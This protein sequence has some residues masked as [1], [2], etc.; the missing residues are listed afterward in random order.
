MKYRHIFSNNIKLLRKHKG[1]TQKEMAEK[2]GLK[3]S[4]SYGDFERKVSE[5]NIN[6]IVKISEI[7]NVS[8]TDLIKLDFG[9]IDIADYFLSTNNQESSNESSLL[10]EVVISKDE[11]I[12]ALKK[13]IENLEQQLK[14]R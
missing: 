5:P 3:S 11:T 8:I 6:Y 10:R 12:E 7:L 4:S 1:Y 13:H 2:L 14:E 9:K